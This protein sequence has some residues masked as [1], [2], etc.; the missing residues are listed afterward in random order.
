MSDTRVADELAVRS[1]IE[2]Y[3]D[4]VCRHDA[5]A[6]EPLWAEDAR[7]SVPDMPELAEVKG[8]EAIMK[9]FRAAQDFFPFTF[10]ICVPGYIDIHHDRATVR[11][12]TTE[13][14]R[15]RDGNTRRAAGVYEDKLAKRNGQ[16]LFI[17]RVWRLLDAA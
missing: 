13:I 6:I 1:M 12:Y 5:A 7:W 14:I 15:D 8:R 2:R 10:L 4:A 17:E 9:A 3:S 11:S 16:W